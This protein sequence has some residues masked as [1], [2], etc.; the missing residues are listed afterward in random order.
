MTRS[1]VKIAGQGSVATGFVV[2][3]PA[4]EG[5]PPSHLLVTADHVLTQVRG[6]EVKVFF[7]KAEPDGSF[8]KAPV[9]LTV[10]RDGK[11]L[12]TKHPT[13]DVAVIAVTPPID[14]QPPGIPD[15]KL[16]SEDDLGRVGAEAGDLVRCAGF[17]HPNQF[18]TGEAGFPVTRLGCVAGASI[19]PSSKSK[20]LLVDLNVF[21]GDSGAAVYLADPNRTNGGAELVLGLVVGQHFIDEE[22]RMTYQAGKLRHRMALAILAPS[23]TIRETIQQL[24]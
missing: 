24:D 14:A 9:P 5:T 17:P 21:E 22:Y 12:W 4:A 6:D 13:A 1:T 2:N 8:S 15:Q 3:R 7:H 16:A 10:R 11:P 18:D 19:L 23:W 20:T